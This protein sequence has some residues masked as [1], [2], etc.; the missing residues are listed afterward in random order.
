MAVKRNKKKKN[1]TF[2]LTEAKI[3]KYDKII[4]YLIGEGKKIEDV[5]INE[6]EDAAAEVGIENFFEV[7]E[8]ILQYFDSKRT[9]VDEEDKEDNDRVVELTEEAYPKDLD[10]VKQYFRDISYYKVLTRE[11]E[12]ELFIRYRD[13]VDEETEK[14]IRTILVQSNVRLVVSVAKKY[15]GRG[16]DFLDLIQEGNFGLLK[17]IDKFDPDRGYKFST[18]APWWIR[19]SITKGIYEKNYVIRHPEHAQTKHEKIVAAIN[20]FLITHG[21]EPDIQEICKMT[22]YS[23]NVVGKYRYMIKIGSTDTPI[24]DNDDN[25]TVGDTLEGADV[26]AGRETEQVIATQRSA[27]EEVIGC[28]QE[29]LYARDITLL[30]FMKGEVNGIVLKDNELKEQFLATQEELDALKMRAEQKEKPLDFEMLDDRLLNLRE[31]VVLSLMFGLVNEKRYK[32]DE[33]GVLLNLTSMRVNQ[34]CA[35]ALGKLRGKITE[36]NSL[37]K[38]LDLS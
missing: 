22:G 4:S 19:Q 30:C 6:I 21:Y 27:L 5:D 7:E 29:N 2:K 11:E 13:A 1:K 35:S 37:R 12:R 28:P 36:V 14:E 9:L 8:E 23:E 16:L 10:L 24:G 3:K 33:V 26:F 34:I 38:Y 18:Y 17:A 32:M 20:S 15:R 31:V 25:L